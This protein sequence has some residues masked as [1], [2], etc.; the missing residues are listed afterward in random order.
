MDNG[1]VLLSEGNKSA[2]LSSREACEAG[3]NCNAIRVR[4][5]FNTLNVPGR[6]GHPEVNEEPV[7]MEE[8]SVRE[9]CRETSVSLLGRDSV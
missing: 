5:A 7:E 4:R 9:G 3:C 6:W 8:V 2:A 1:Y